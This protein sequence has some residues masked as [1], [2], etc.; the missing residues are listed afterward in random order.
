MSFTDRQQR[1][2]WKS[3]LLHPSHRLNPFSIFLLACAARS[4]FP[5][6][7]TRSAQRSVDW[8]YWV[9]CV[10]CKVLIVISTMLCCKPRWIFHN[11][12]LCLVM[13]LEERKI[14]CRCSRCECV[15]SNH[16]VQHAGFW[17]REHHCDDDP[18]RKKF[19]TNCLYLV[20]L[21]KSR[22]ESVCQHATIFFKDLL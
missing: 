1:E 11:K 20:V 10:C 16:C 15:A 7:Q 21:M 8:S 4:F 2:R 5:A 3:G 18:P 6:L 9:V 13:L 14:F 17:A 19:T 12:G 22:P